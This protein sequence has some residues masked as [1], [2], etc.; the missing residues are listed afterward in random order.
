MMLEDILLQLA[1]ALSGLLPVAAGG[2]D[3]P[4]QTGLRNDGDR[5]TGGIVS[6][7]PLSAQ[8]AARPTL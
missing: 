4:L 7:S 3:R 1:A 2:R 5:E 6:A 8:L